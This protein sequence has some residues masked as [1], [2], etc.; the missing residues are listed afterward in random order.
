VPS[1]QRQKKNKPSV[2][3]P[4]YINKIFETDPE[5][6]YYTNRAL[7]YQN[8]IE[9]FKIT[10]KEFEERVDEELIDGKKIEKIEG[11][12]LHID[13]PSFRIRELEHWLMKNNKQFL[14]FYTDSKSHTT[15]NTRIAN[16]DKLIKNCIHDLESSQLLVKIQ[17]VKS[18]IAEVIDVI[19]SLPDRRYNDEADLALG[20]EQQK[21]RV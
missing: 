7:L 11:I 20:I 19:R 2:I 6:H 16:N 15:M 17:T 18:A 10:E 8:I 1:I 14:N 13:P 21:N 4:F 9:Y 3:E 5:A 12:E